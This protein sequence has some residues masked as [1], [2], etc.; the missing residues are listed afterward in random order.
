MPVAP[1]NT[2]P[3]LI[4]CLGVVANGNPP[5]YIAQQGEKAMSDKQIEI[6]QC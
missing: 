6:F 3:H 5:A 1:A 4:D 2:S